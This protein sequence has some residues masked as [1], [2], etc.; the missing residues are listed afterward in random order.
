MNAAG[1][2]PSPAVTYLISPL[3]LSQRQLASAK[4][5]NPIQTA[6]K[7]SMQS[8][9][10]SCKK[11]LQNAS[12]CF[13]LLHA[14]LCTRPRSG[15]ADRNAQCRELSLLGSPPPLFLT[16]IGSHILRNSYLRSGPDL[17]I[18]HEPNSYIAVNFSRVRPRLGNTPR[19]PSGPIR[20]FQGKANYELRPS[21]RRLPCSPSHLN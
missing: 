3:Q 7:S 13:I 14:H 8:R 4:C 12:K 10:I 18:N 6:S 9:A 19:S 21:R 15:D 2:S 5:F 20:I 11:M 17:A 16:L 1:S